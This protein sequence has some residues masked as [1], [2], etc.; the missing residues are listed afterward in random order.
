[1]SKR[2]LSALNV[3]TSNLLPNHLKKEGEVIIKVHSATV[4]SLGAVQAGTD[5]RWT[6]RAQTEVLC[7]NLELWTELKNGFPLGQDGI[8]ESYYNL[9]GFNG[10]SETP[11]KGQVGAGSPISCFMAHLASWLS[12]LGASGL[13]YRSCCSPL[14][15]TRQSQCAGLPSCLPKFPCAVVEQAWVTN[16]ET[17]LPVFTPPL[18]G[19]FTLGKLFNRDG[20]QSLHL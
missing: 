5:K 1:M 4:L 7:C 18:T 11:E 19:G 14:K 12:P 10:F 13:S 15:H 6:H 16:S 17:W 2:F 20:T 8:V 3:Y 9:I